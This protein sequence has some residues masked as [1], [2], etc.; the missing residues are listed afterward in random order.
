MGTINISN[1]SIMNHE[2]I[3]ININDHRLIF[4]TMGTIN[5]L[6]QL[7]TLLYPACHLPA[8]FAKME[9]LENFMGKC[10]KKGDFTGICSWKL[11]KD[12]DSSWEFFIGS[13]W[14]WTHDPTAAKQLDLKL[15]FSIH[16]QY[17]LKIQPFPMD[18]GP[19]VISRH[20]RMCVRLVR[21][22][23]SRG[24]PF[25]SLNMLKSS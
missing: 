13:S 9:S 19:S 3:V 18:P 6:I 21:H 2:R 7:V 10:P 25:S 11:R 8:L 24:T 20:H 23:T 15:Y 17:S 4:Y 5:I 22:K 16:S 14:D 1:Q 12:C